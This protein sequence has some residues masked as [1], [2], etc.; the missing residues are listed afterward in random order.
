[1]AL[2]SPISGGRSV[3]V[4]FSR[5]E[6]LELFFFKEEWHWFHIR[7][8]QCKQHYQLKR[9]IRRAILLKHYNSNNNN[10]NKNKKVKLS[11]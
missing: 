8:H 9:F 4:G 7:Q 2:T 3:D 6:A 5:T 1:L 10:S 11:P